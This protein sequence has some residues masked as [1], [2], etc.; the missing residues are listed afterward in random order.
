M[1]T[2]AQ[3]APQKEASSMRKNATAQKAEL[4]QI[5]VQPVLAPAM[6]LAQR[7]AADIGSLSQPETAALQHAVGMR[8]VQ[9]L[10]ARNHA[11]ARPDARR[12]GDA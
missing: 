12:E 4:N 11:P 7:A 2:G 3:Q 6:R 10:A 9:R 1:K 8:A 5:E